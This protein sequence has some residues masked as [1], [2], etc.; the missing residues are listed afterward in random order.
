MT[1]RTM[2]VTA[3]QFSIDGEAWN[4]KP[5]QLVVCEYHNGEIVKRVRV[6]LRPVDVEDLAA[7]LWE[8]HEKYA[9][10][11][12]DMTEALRNPTATPPSP[13]SATAE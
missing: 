1:T 5:L 9:K 12:K 6:P 7:R 2:T 3:D 13:H 8:I 11:V 10:A 4:G